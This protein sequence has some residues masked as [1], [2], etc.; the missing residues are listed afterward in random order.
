MNIEIRAA[1]PADAALIHH[2]I[3]ELAIYEKA[4]HEV[5]TSIA[6]IQQSLF[7]ADTP[8]GALICEIDGQPA[9]YAV[10]FFSYS[11]WLGRKGM[12]LEDL[13]ISPAHRGSGAGKKMLRHL[14]RIACDAGCGRLEWS[15]LDWNEP[16]IQFYLSLGASPQDEWIRYRMAGDILTAF[17]AGADKKSASALG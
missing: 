4:E 14:A 1:Q 15:V 7:A 6:E 3:T 13:Y 9:G 11:T 5:V 8:A 10:Y 2:Y 12:Y 16:A 17:A